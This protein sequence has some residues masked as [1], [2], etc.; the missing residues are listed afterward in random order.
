[1]PSEQALIEAF[2]ALVRKWDPDIFVGYEVGVFQIKYFCLSPPFSATPPPMEHRLNRM[3]FVTAD[4]PDC[5]KGAHSLQGISERTL[6]FNT[7]F[8]ISYIIER[9]LL[10]EINNNHHEKNVE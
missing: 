6:Q 7:I 5:V 8:Y 1:M 3:L 4:N 9:N 2:V 10:F